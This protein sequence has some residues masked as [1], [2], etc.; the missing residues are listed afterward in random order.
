MT[1][2]AAV[3]ARLKAYSGLSS[4]VSTRVYN[5]FAKAATAKPYVV[6]LCQMPVDFDA[7]LDSSSDM[8]TARVQVDAW[9]ETADGARAVGLQVRAALRDFAGVSSGVTIADIEAAGGFSDRD[10]DVTPALYR[11]T[12]DFLITY[13][14]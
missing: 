7:D 11:T 2:D 1:I 6:F 3:N 14:Q 5:G 10:D 8:V 13:F 9:A 4:L 12:Q